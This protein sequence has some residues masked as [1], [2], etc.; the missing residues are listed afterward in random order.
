[1]GVYYIYIHTHTRVWEIPLG[2]TR[3]C[4]HT[5]GR[6]KRTSRRPHTVRTCV[7]VCVCISRKTKLISTVSVSR[8]FVHVG[9]TRMMLKYNFTIT[10]PLAIWLFRCR[11]TPPGMAFGQNDWRARRIRPNRQGGGRRGKI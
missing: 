10:A 9:L 5:V 8:L 4:T 11:A 2:N 1:M 7:C 3:V 6:F